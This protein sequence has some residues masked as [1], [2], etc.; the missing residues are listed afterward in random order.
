MVLLFHQVP[1][2]EG[3]NSIKRADCI[4]INGNKNTKFEEKI[5]KI[6]KNIQIF[7]SKYKIKI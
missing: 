6:N 1:L 7:Y 2:R 5:N 4:F 3:L